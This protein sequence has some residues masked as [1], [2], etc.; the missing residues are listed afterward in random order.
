MGGLWLAAP[1]HI[2]LLS[3]SDPTPFHRPS[4]KMQPGLA[5]GF[6]HTG[7]PA[8]TVTHVVGDRLTAL[9]SL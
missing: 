2:F 4:N 6:G 7:Y 8:G 3:D 1:T 5:S 9:W